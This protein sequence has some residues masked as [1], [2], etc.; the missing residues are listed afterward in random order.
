MQSGLIT[1]EDAVDLVTVR[2]GR[3]SSVGTVVRRLRRG[4]ELLKTLLGALAGLV[5]DVGVWMAALR[6]ASTRFS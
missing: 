1:A 6:H 3:T 5:I 2:V 4:A